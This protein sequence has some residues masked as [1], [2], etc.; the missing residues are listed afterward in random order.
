MVSYLSKHCTM[1]VVL[2]LSRRKKER[3]TALVI[4]AA[5]KG[6]RAI[7][8]GEWESEECIPQSDMLCDALL[9][10]SAKAL[11]VCTIGVCIHLGPPL[12]VAPREDLV[13]EA[14]QTLYERHSF[15]REDLF[16]QTK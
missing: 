16:L 13:G 2:S 10:W 15:K 3:T 8:T 5:L 1:W 4:A 9:S 7:D 12:S 14:L 11:Q 6:F